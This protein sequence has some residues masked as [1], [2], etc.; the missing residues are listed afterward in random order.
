MQTNKV[1]EH[2]YFAVTSFAMHGGDTDYKKGFIALLKKKGVNSFQILCII[3][4][5]CEHL[6]EIS[7]GAGFLSAELS[8]T[9]WICLYVSDGGCRT[10]VLS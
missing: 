6:C 1:I 10:G 7:G 9:T 5:A 4:M 2:G 3:L 8:K